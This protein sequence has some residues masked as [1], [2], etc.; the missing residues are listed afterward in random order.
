[1]QEP[2]LSHTVAS[3]RP[4]A[5]KLTLRSATPTSDAAVRLRVRVAGGAD[6][7]SGG[8]ASGM[9]RAAVARGN[10]SA[11]AVLPTGRSPTATAQ[12][13]QD[14]ATGRPVPGTV[15][16]IY[17]RAAPLDTST[18]PGAGGSSLGASA[19]QQRST[20]PVDEAQPQA[21]GPDRRRA[22]SARLSLAILC[23][24]IRQTP[25]LCAACKAWRCCSSRSNEQQFT[26]VHLTSFILQ[27]S[28]C[29]S[30]CE[31]LSF[32]APSAPMRRD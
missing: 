5:A 28:C 9:R 12:L 27:L 20:A 8:P 19:V 30:A 4:A 31:L 3:T 16:V 22:L 26:S 21:L 1:M 17:L 24:R 6:H 7:T 32:H 11:A 14:G 23:Q 15:L 25:C 10:A 18:A 13:R 29:C 2:W